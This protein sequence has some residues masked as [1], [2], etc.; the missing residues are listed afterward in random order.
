MNIA[1]RI[2]NLRKMK[3]ISQEELADKVGV[4]RQA[5][6]KWESEQ[7]SPDLDK[8]IIMSD[9]FEVTTDYILKGIEPPKQ[10]G[11]ENDNFMAGQILYIASTAFIVIGLLCAFA[12]WHAEQTAESIWGSMIIQVV[13]I[14]GYLIAKIISKAKAPFLVNYLNV[15]IILFM[16][17]SLF[18]GVVFNRIVAPYPVDIISAL[19]FG[20]AYSITIGLTFVVLRKL[21]K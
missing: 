12:G 21:A 20:I 18:V 1:D 4:S 9:Y 16:P 2:Q 3:G 7:S 6:S 15:I 5:V 8:I 13:G 10:A 11:E 17:I 14:V 19:F